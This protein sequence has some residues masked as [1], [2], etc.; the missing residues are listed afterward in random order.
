MAAATAAVTAKAAEDV[1]QKE[2]EQEVADVQTGDGNQE[3][4]LVEGE[5]AKQLNKVDKKEGSTVPPH[6][7]D[8]K[9]LVMG[10]VGSDRAATEVA[11]AGMPFKMKASDHGNSP[12]QKNFGSKEKRGFPMSNFGV[13]STEKQGGVGSE[14]E[15]PL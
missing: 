9:P 1:A 14:M 11:R 12:I 2:N 15:P 3:A 10:G 6:S 7:H 5:T 4:T 13:N 8:E